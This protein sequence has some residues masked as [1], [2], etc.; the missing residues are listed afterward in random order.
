MKSAN[1]LVGDRYAKALIELSSAGI[2]ISNSIADDLK[3]V[4][5]T[6]E[7]SHELK[8][9][10]EH[11]SY[12]TNQ[13]IAVLDKLFKGKVQDLTL[14]L[15][16]LLANRRRLELLPAIRDSYHRLL[17][18]KQNIVTARLI[19]SEALSPSNLADIKARLNEYLGKNLILETAIDPS[20]IAGFILRIGDQVIDGSLKGR[21][22]NLEKV[23]L[24]V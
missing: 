20:L 2:S 4:T 22:N 14:R 8:A 11:P 17:N 12:S 6:I 18:E 10:L 21:L 3:L 19:S 9:A 1:D 13:K 5:E 23:L 7:N 16:N 24:S 15:L